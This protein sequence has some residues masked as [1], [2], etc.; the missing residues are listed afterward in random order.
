MSRPSAAVLPLL[1]VVSG[2]M[3]IG[4]SGADLDLGE[5][6]LA[7]ELSVD[8][9]R[10][11]VGAPIIA[12][13]VVHN[14]GEAPVSVPRPSRDTLEFFLR[15]LESPEPRHTQVVGW[16]LENP[17]FIALE[18]GQIDRRRFVLNLATSEP[19]DF[20]LFA[21]YRTEADPAVRLT[22][23]PVASNAVPVAVRPPRVLE[24]DGMGLIS[25]DEARR[26]AVRHFGRS[27]AQVDAVLAKDERVRHHVWWVTVH[28]EAPAAGDA[29]HGSCF[30]DPFL[31]RVR[32]ETAKVVV[33]PEPE[34]PEGAV[35]EPPGA[36]GTPVPGAED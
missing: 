29:T 17:E 19:G 14:T 6:T 21:I 26:I 35:I 12:E 36:S 11:G 10:Y 22:A 31:G 13:V 9:A 33:I 32:S 27:A 4:K 18:P 1:L 34:F 8:D 5:P 7:V 16:V 24:R 28:F 30:I 2:C 20:E 15:P 3:G 25:E 23:T